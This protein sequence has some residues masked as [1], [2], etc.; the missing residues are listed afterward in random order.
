MADKTT[1]GGEVERKDEAKN[2]AKEAVQEIR[3]GNKE[4]GKFLAEE[5]RDLDPAAAAEVLEQKPA[6]ASKSKKS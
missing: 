3:H 6:R 1:Q 5:A 2:L 4:E